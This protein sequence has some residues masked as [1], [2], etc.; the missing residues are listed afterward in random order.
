M[1]REILNSSCAQ[2][3]QPLDKIWTLKILPV[4]CQTNTLL[5]SEGKRE[6]NFLIIVAL[7]NN[8]FVTST[9]R[10][11][12]LASLKKFHFFATSK[13]SWHLGDVTAFKQS[14]FPSQL[15]LIWKWEHFNTILIAPIASN[16]LSGRTLNPFWEFWF[17][18]QRKPKKA[19]KIYGSAKH[20][21]YPTFF[22]WHISMDTIRN[23]RISCQ[24]CMIMST[25]QIII[26]L[27]EP[28][29]N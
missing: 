17:W 26:S 9:H 24:A 19:A 6:V 18:S 7:Q 3:K 4:R 10:A 23:A 16:G 5:N 13:S 15:G 12:F 14:L 28:Q 11:S 29:Q 8:F 27:Q 20:L 21:V 22:G 2:R 1:N 25:H